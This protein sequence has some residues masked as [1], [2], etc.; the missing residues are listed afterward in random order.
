[1]KILILAGGAEPSQNFN[2]HK[3]HVDRLVK[4]AHA[5]GV[6]ADDIVIFWAD[7]HDEAADRAIRTQSKFDFP[8]ALSGHAWTRSLSAQVE[9]VDTRFPG[10]TVYPARREA[11]QKWF[12]E[13]GS[14]LGEGDRL[15]IAVTDHGQRGKGPSGQSSVS[16]WHEEWTA[17]Q[18]YADIKPISESVQIAL[19]MSQCYSGGFASITWRRLNMCGAFSAEPTR[20]AY[21]CYPDLAVKEHVGHFVHFLDGLV[22]GGTLADGHR[23]AILTDETPDTPHLA[24]QAYLR[25]RIRARV[26][27]NKTS[28][29]IAVDS[30]LAVDSKPEKWTFIAQLSHRYGLKGLVT[31]FED[32]VQQLSQVKAMRAA[33]EYGKI[34]G[35]LRGDG[36]V[37]FVLRSSGV[38]T[39][40][41]RSDGPEKDKL[42]ARLTKWYAS[43]G[44]I[45]DRLEHLSKRV[46]VGKTLTEMLDVREA[47]LVRISYLMLDIAG[48]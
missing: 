5:K 11:L 47:A 40:K 45:H 28:F 15:L 26:Q 12:S 31:R 33:L 8:S 3:V 2:S 20:L 48:F 14:K 9:L 37:I 42:A 27:K 23:Q 44:K 19:W 7:G 38:L 39:E 35:H 6:S 10:Y 46:K 13:Y 16:L 24:S 36:R 41:Q 29:S 22:H 30:A 17:D 21:G 34:D 32:V 1:M 18:A 25:D 43:Q 4:A